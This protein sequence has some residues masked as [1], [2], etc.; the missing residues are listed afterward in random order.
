MPLSFVAEGWLWRRGVA[1]TIGYCLGLGCLTQDL[2]WVWVKCRPSEMLAP[3]PRAGHV[4]L[5]KTSRVLCFFAFSLFKRPLFNPLCSP[6]LACR[7]SKGREPSAK[8][9]ITCPLFC[10]VIFSPLLPLPMKGH[11]R[12][13]ET[14]RGWD[15]ACQ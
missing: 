12:A 10:C 1:L 7:A 8:L 6:S 15:A 11:C 13:A 5:S 2:Q 9:S 14:G 4:S 3:S